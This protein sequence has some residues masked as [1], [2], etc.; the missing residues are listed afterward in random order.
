MFKSPN[1]RKET[2]T[3]QTFVWSKTSLGKYGLLRAIHFLTSFENVTWLGVAQYFPRLVLLPE[4]VW[5]V[6]LYFLSIDIFVL[7]FFKVHPLVLWI[8][9]YTDLERQKSCHCTAESSLHFAI[10]EITKS[11][12][13]PLEMVWN[14][15]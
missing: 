11:K 15:Q 10:S 2:K 1:N 7:N 12:M 3:V 4:K 14:Y 13:K 8:T 9:A 5:T 6:L